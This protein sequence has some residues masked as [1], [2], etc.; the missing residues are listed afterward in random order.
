MYCRWP[1]QKTTHV[2]I[3]QDTIL[4]NKQS[5]KDL[6]WTQKIVS[7]TWYMYPFGCVCASEIYD[8]PHCR[9][10]WFAHISCVVIGVPFHVDT[11]VM[12]LFSWNSFL[13]V[14]TAQIWGVTT[15]DQLNYHP[16]QL[17]RQKLQSTNSFS[18]PNST[19]F[20]PLPLGPWYLTAFY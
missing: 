4:N 13:V 3:V 18:T 17:N 15:R 2:Y 20:D 14:V 12:S 16:K 19:T 6:H 5:I 11:W 10:C 7:N 9:L 8:F 1:T